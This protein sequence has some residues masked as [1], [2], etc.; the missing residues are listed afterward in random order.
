MPPRPL[1]ESVGLWLTFLA[2]SLRHLPRPATARGISRAAM[3]RH[4]MD[5]AEQTDGYSSAWDGAGW[6]SAGGARKETRRTGTE[7][8]YVPVASTSAVRLDSPLSLTSTPT[9]LTSSSRPYEKLRRSKPAPSPPPTDLPDAL[10]RLRALHL[11]CPH[12]SPLDLIQ[13]IRPSPVTDEDEVPPPTPPPPI[14]LDPQPHSDQRR[15]LTPFILQALFLGA[16]ALGLLTRRKVRSADEPSW[17]PA[18]Q[19][20]ELARREAEDRVDE[21]Q[22]LNLLVGALTVPPKA[23]QKAEGTVWDWRI[24]SLRSLL[25]I[26]ESITARSE[27]VDRTTIASVLQYA[28]PRPAA[29]ARNNQT[30]LYVRDRPAL[31]LWAWNAFSALPPSPSNLLPPSSPPYILSPRSL[32]SID[33]ALLQSFLD[34]VYSNGSSD[35]ATPHSR[36]IDTLASASSVD[37]QILN[38]VAKHVLARRAEASA[39]LDEALAKA[40][41]RACRLDILVDLLEEDGVLDPKRRLAIASQALDLLARSGT[42]SAARQQLLPSLVVEFGRAVSKL[43]DFR[44]EELDLVQGGLQHLYRDVKT[45]GAVHRPIRDIVLAV[46]DKTPEAAA[47]HPRLLSDALKHFVRHSQPRSALTI[48]R[49]I[50]PHLVRLGHYEAVL[51]SPYTPLS[52]FAWDALLNSDHLKPHLSSLLA[53]IR[54]HT[55]H[56]ASPDTLSSAFSAVSLANQLDLPKS[57]EAYQLLLSVVVRFASDKA[58]R[59]TLT[60][61]QD[62]G[63][64]P[65]EET[66]AVL[67]S[68]EMV[69][70]DVQKRKVVEINEHGQR[71]L[72]IVERRRRRG[73]ETQTK[74][75]G[76]A[77][78][79]AQAQLAAQNGGVERET[80]ALA[81]V[82]LESIS[83]LRKEVSTAQLVE[84]TK[85]HLGVDLSPLR[86]RLAAT[87]E[88]VVVRPL[89]S[90][91]LRWSFLP[92][93]QRTYRILR[94][95][96]EV[97][98]EFAL[99]KA[100]RA[101]YKR[102]ETEVRKAET[103]KKRERRR[104]Q[105]EEGRGGKEGGK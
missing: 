12:L 94:K 47:T 78:R 55:H 59:R 49:V 77:V 29:V 80:P 96:F 10:C 69:R 102:E 65:N 45:D 101:A 17:R 6:A 9:T 76:A 2:P 70:Q 72:H 79:N 31:A 44:S 81:A 5:R 83:R 71:E 38:G 23:V 32:P 82:L 3:Q 97:R 25:G 93:R 1:V 56:T 99:A 37:R 15:F 46:L 89:A 8:D 73:R 88:P 51:S 52:S 35:Q 91:E 103:A 18:Q 19:D 26:V 27:R 20:T 13:R 74:L 95:G 16:S 34:L 64:E 60:R 39:G 14:R 100:L 86:S 50:P 68:R 63:I 87:A 85:E 30:A 4:G 54:S 75:V 58:V 41:V 62:A 42:R 28:A 24:E 33:S 57:G 105:Q 67:C 66:L 90:H 53:F 104:K 11:A 43:D 22:A 61:M 36:R 92:A 98:A 84:L 21:L 40:A 7:W 48:L